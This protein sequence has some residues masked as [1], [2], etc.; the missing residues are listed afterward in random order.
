MSESTRKKIIAALMVAALIWGYNNFKPESPQPVERQQSASVAQP[1]AP[2]APA[3]AKPK[4][5]NVEQ[6]SKE[7]WGSDPFRVVKGAAAQTHSRVSA[8]KWKLSGIFYNSDS[9]VA[10]IN[11]KRV[12][13]GDTVSEAK[14]ISIDKETVKLQ[15]NGNTMTLTVTKG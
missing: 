11:N 15:Y 4:L 13:A 6:K 3:P 8:L 9:P 10:I 12:K 1:A 5:V 7:P 2:T 14:V